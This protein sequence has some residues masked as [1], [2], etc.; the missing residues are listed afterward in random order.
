M[1]TKKDECIVDIRNKASVNVSNWQITHTVD[2]LTTVN[3]KFAVLDKINVLINQ[4]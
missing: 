4:E 2:T 3:N 1:I